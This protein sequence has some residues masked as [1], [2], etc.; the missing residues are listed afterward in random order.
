MTQSLDLTLYTSDTD[1]WNDTGCEPELFL[2]FL[3]LNISFYKNKCK[4]KNKQLLHSNQSMSIYKKI[5][6]T[7]YVF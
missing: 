5:Y 7:K 1:I 3:G 4:F 6:F 2:R